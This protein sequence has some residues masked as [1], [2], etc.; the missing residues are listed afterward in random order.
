MR[1][2]HQYHETAQVLHNRR[3]LFEP[4]LHSEVE[5]IA[6]YDGHATLTV[7]GQNYQMEAGDFLL[8]APY[9]I[10]SYTTDEDVEV[11]K[12]IFAPDLLAEM[13]RV[14]DDRYPNCPVISRQQAEKAGLH[15]LSREI[16]ENY[17][18]VSPPMQRAYLTLL[19]GKL[20]NL[21]QLRERPMQTRD[22]ME[23]VFSYCRE[24][25]R[26][27]LTRQT[28]AQALHISESHLS[29]LFCCK[30]KINFCH[31]INTL[32]INEACRLLTETDKSVIDI[33]EESGFSSLRSFNRVFI[34][35][36]GVTPTAYRKRT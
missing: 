29:H 10:H 13:G 16:L 24:H 5:I 20:L 19:T 12:F 31:Y 21:C 27:K 4:H 18:Q 11:G 22:T 14:F 34:K 17:R 33:G 26:E 23:Q 36:C 8:V 2:F 1:F 28:V 6:L 30:L 15:R 35:H 9:C 3:I 25:F 32:R 7:D